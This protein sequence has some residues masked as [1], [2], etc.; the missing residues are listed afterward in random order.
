MS[1]ANA[2]TEA[3]TATAPRYL[4]ELNQ[5]VD[6]RTVE[7]IA[8]RVGDGGVHVVVPATPP[9]S[10]WTYTDDEVRSRAHRELRRGIGW[11]RGRGI[12]ADGE[13]GDANP[14]EAIRDAA[15][16]RRFDRIVVAGEGKRH[17]L[18]RR[19]GLDLASR[20]RRAGITF[21]Q[22]VPQGSR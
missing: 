6:R 5:P 20:L 17:G 10:G 19:L 9:R 13:V 8:G 4:V 18:A 11:L 22:V 21:V 14:V 16:G 15:R 2:V 3:G 12:Q 7:E 1:Q